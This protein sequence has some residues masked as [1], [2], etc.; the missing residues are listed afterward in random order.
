MSLMAAGEIVLAGSIN[1]NN[2]AQMAIRMFDMFK[3]PSNLVYTVNMSNTRYYPTSTLL[4]S[5][6]IMI[7]GGQSIAQYYE[8]FD[9]N[10]PLA[11]PL[12]QY[13][14]DPIWL[15][16]VNAMLCACSLRVTSYHVINF[17]L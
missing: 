4:P 17:N 13:P 16:Q 5:G 6:L 1:N 7:I 9:S 3:D 8:I 11:T 15:A 12:P 14:I 10:S 2:D